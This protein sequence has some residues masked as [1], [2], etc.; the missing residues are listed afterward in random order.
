MENGQASYSAWYEWYPAPLTSFDNFEVKPGD[1][2]TMKVVATSK[3]SGTATVTNDSTGKSVTKTFA[4]QPSLCQQNAEWIVE[5]FATGGDLIPFAAFTPVHITDAK[6]QA[7]GNT[8]G[9]DGATLINIKQDD[10][11]LTDCHI[12]GSTE[13]DCSYTQS[14]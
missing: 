14:K 6:W 10:K 12:A 11:V 4:N 2:V 13:V 7:N 9:L 1:T 5:D 8:Y 3:T